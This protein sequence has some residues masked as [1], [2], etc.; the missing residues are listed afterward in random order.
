MADPTQSV[1]ST[2][3]STPALRLRDYTA[4]R[5]SLGR[6][7]VSLATYES[8]AFQLAHAQARDAVHAALDIEGISRRICVQNAGLSVL[9][10]ASAAADRATYLRRP[11]LG[12]RLDSA[13][14]ELLGA[15][16]YDVVFVIADGL[17]AT[18]VERHSI[19]LLSEVLRGLPEGWRVAP[20]CVVRQ[21]RV[22]IG[23]EIG[24]LLGARLSVVLIGERPGLSSPDS[25][26]AYITWAPGPGRVDAERNCV[27]NVHGNGLSY[28]AA[29]ARILFYCMEARR[30]ELSGT[31]LKE[32]DRD[33]LSI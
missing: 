25:L 6:T 14:V 4:A 30:L 9:G 7:G 11:D 12:R 31:R 22:G 20:V 1:S 3:A 2:P 19:P 28:A 13:S 16:V 21:G 33:L 5:V 17:S 26:G 10:L 23:D 27:S 8:L 15:G 29:A 32:M 24:S 18:A